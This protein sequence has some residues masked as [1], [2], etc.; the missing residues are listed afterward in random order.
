MLNIEKY[1][2]KL[3]NLGVLNPDTLA[4]IDGKP[5]MCQETECNMCELYSEE[6]CCVDRTDNWLFSEHKEPEIDWSKVKVDTPILV[7]N[8]EYENIWFNKYFAR[9]ENGKVYVWKGGKTSWT[10]V[11]ENDVVGWDYAKLA[12]SEEQ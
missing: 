6:S 7:R 4:V 2:D 5:C 3:E 8:L 9:Y 11:D 10:A 1:K 12:E